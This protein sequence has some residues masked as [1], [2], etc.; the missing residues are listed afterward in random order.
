HARKKHS[1]DAKF[2]T[3]RHVEF[4]DRRDWYYEKIDVGEDVEAARDQ[5][6]EVHPV[7]ASRLE[8]VLAEEEGEE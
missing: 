6:E 7:L 8:R 3:Q 5:D 2:L 1:Q 4:R